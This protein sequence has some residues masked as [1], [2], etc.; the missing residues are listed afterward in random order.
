MISADGDTYLKP[1]RSGIFRAVEIEIEPEP[2]YEEIPP[3]PPPRC[4]RSKS[5]VELCQEVEP[6]VQSRQRTWSGEKK[7]NAKRRSDP[8]SAYY[9]T[10]L[11][12]Q[13][14]SRRSWHQESKNLRVFEEINCTE[15]RHS[16]SR[17]LYEYESR[18]GLTKSKI[19]LVEEKTKVLA[20]QISVDDLG[21]EQGGESLPLP[22]RTKNKRRMTKSTFIK[23]LI[24]IGVVSVVAVVAY[25]IYKYRGRGSE[26]SDMSSQVTMNTTVNSTLDESLED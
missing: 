12:K 8:L 4:R 11:P 25:L 19:S 26:S 16:R 6:L 20:E 22:Q 1:R 3:T 13:S 18:N 24:V 21:T 14:P 17:I 15:G 5:E 9:E 23:S 10:R 2:E 7:N